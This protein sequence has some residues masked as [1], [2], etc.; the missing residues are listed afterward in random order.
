MTSSHHPCFKEYLAYSYGILVAMLSS[1][2]GQVLSPP[3][4]L[5]ER[6]RGSKRRNRTLVHGI[7]SK[8]LSL[9][10]SVENS[11]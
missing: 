8:L 2:L 11:M 5:L 6:M 4:G 7:H 1:V 9:E 3:V 10:T